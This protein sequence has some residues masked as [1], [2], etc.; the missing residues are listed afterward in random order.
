VLKI[1]QRNALYRSGP[2]GVQDDIDAAGLAGYLGGVPL[3]RIFVERIDHCR[4]D[5]SASSGYV[6]CDSLDGP[7]GTPT[8][9][10]AR[11]FTTESPCYG[12]ANCTARAVDYAY[13][14]L[15]QHEL[16]SLSLA[17]VRARRYCSLSPGKRR[18]CSASSRAGLS[19][20]LLLMVDPYRRGSA[21]GTEH[22][23]VTVRCNHL[24]VA[25]DDTTSLPAR[26]NVPGKIVQDDLP[27]LTLLLGSVS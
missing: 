11:S 27:T 23:G 21:A 12:T 20:W 2:C 15:Q 17:A 22:S 8:Q 7:E 16:I 14:A 9:E 1:D 24:L 3:H 4:L 25:V 13:L 26:L 19:D 5:R 10:E 18:L 6:A